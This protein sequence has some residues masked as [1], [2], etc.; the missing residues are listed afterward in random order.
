MKDLHR[1]N[2]ELLAENAS[3]K[4]RI[5][6]LEASEESKLTP[7][8]EALRAPES[9]LNNIIEHSPVATWISDPRGTLIYLNQ[10]CRELLHITDA[11]VVGKYNILQDTVV[12]EQG[13]LPLVKQ[14]FEQGMSARFIIEYD[15]S[16]LKNLDL[17]KPV[18]VVLETTVLPVHDAD[19]RVIRAVIQHIDITER[20]RAEDALRESEE[21]FSLFMEQ[22]PAAVFIKDGQGRML[23]ANRYLQ[24]LFGWQ[25]CVGKL[26]EELLPPEVAERMVADDRTVMAE[27]PRVIQEKVFDIK[28]I[29]RIFVT[30]KFPVAVLGK[31][32]LLGAIAVD[33]TERVTA[34]KDLANTKVLLQ[35]AFEQTP[36]PMVLVRAPDGILLNINRACAE[37]L[38]IE[39]EGDYVGQSLPETNPTWQDFDDKGRLIPWTELPLTLALQGITT[40]DKEMVVLRKDGTMR[41]EMVNAAPIYNEAGEMI[42]AFVVFPDI[43]YRKRAEEE[44]TKLEAQLQQ[45][46]KMEAIG[47]LA[48]GIAHD[49]NN[50]L[51]GIQ[52]YTSLSLLNLDTTHPN[53]ERLKRIEEQVQS[54]ADLTRQLLGFARGGR[55]EVKPAAM[56][57]I[58]EKTYSMFGRTKKELSIYKKYEKYL[59]NVD[60]DRGQME[61]VFMNLYV[62]AWQAMPGGGEIYLETQ[63]V[64][65]DDEQALLLTVNPGRYVKISVADTG[66]GMDEK[67]KE[68]IFDPFFTTKEMGRGTGLGLATVYGIIKGHGGMI[69][70]DS[71]PGHGT[72]FTIY[73]PASEQEVVKEQ[74]VTGIIVGGTETILLVDDEKIILDVNR[75]LLESM[76]YKVYAAGS[77]QEAIAVYMEKRNEIALVILDMIMPGISGGNT[78]DRL[79]EINPE[80]RVLLSSGYSI[81][82]EAQQILNR[83]CNGFIQKPFKMSTLARNIKEILC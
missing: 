7:A 54:G 8:V 10:A 61:Q 6:E 66:T 13:Y 38:G 19:M 24:E 59:W 1:T 15:S 82:G 56:N 40:V 43:T 48:G 81:N 18:F 55:Y 27:G 44:K 60:V 49:F 77:G 42:A 39:G 83:G 62:N 78:F 76:G 14:V 5:T 28:D 12:I 2:Q 58:L 51:M 53:H 41:W 67:T 36:V 22:L 63:N 71:E 79:R 25:D 47:T 26:T 45:A 37:V 29:E 11:E 73:L 65:L 17:S 35:A 16:R 21:R 75:E 70:V 33:I 68:R 64:L 80:I 3:L 57:D 30:H 20:K 32:T 46:Q 9:F 50:L 23:F 72:T 34:E 52:G 31:P 69:D 4:Q 74:A